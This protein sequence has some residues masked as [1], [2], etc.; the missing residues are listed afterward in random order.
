MTVERAI[1]AGG[2]FWG[3]EEIFSG[4][5]GVVSVTSGYTG[6]NT[7]NPTYKEVRAGGTGHAEAVLVEF[8]PEAADYGKLVRIFFELH[9]PAQA[10][11]QGPDLGAQYR[12]AV[13]YI[14]ERQKEEALRALC[15]LKGHGIPAVTELVPAGVFYPAEEY[16]QRYF[17]KN[18]D[19]LSGSCHFR[20][21]IDWED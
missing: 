9:D 13:F 17:K 18:P 16:H 12:S 4:V 3:V 5:D 21:E 10:G 2:C 7:E 20:R 11:G 14:G 6:G 15:F 19:R 1:F 8:D